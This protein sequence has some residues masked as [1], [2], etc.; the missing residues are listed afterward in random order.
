MLHVVNCRVFVCGNSAL[1]KIVTLFTNM[2]HSDFTIE[3][4]WINITHLYMYIDSC[5]RHNQ[6][7]ILRQINSLIIC[8]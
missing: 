7:K 2:S 8:V 3:A 5:C 4:A 1:N 6:R